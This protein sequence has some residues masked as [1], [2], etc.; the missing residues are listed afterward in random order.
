M[1]SVSAVSGVIA[2]AG[3]SS[4]WGPSSFKGI[5]NIS[6]NAGLS[7]ATTAGFNVIREFLPDIL[8]RRKH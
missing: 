5:G 3:V 8:H 1:F 7:F 6:E 4:I 2:A